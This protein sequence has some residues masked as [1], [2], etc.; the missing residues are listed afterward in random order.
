MSE[1]VT[2]GDLKR[3]IT[4]TDLPDDMMVIVR[5]FD[6]ETCGVE[7][8]DAIQHLFG[9]REDGEEKFLELGIAEIEY[10][11]NAEEEAPEI[12]EAETVEE[13]ETPIKKPKEKL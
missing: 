5:G 12:L 7:S 4:L 10:E 11:E 2:V 13:P 8:I 6:G 1:F 3:L 9:D